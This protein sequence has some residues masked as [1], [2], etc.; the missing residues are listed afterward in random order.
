[1]QGSTFIGFLFGEAGIESSL[2][3]HNLNSVLL[4]VPLFGDCAIILSFGFSPTYELLGRHFLVLTR[5]LSL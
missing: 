5:I 1:M 3:F 2:F 4:S